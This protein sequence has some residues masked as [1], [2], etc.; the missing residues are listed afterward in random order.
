M[1]SEP[2]TILHVF[3]TFPVGDGNMAAYSVSHAFHGRLLDI[4]NHPAVIPVRLKDVE[5][6]ADGLYSEQALKARFG[7]SIAEYDMI[8]E[9]YSP[10]H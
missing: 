9:K 1:I 8:R 10:D 3:A 6:N 7:E 2:I 5:R 4:R